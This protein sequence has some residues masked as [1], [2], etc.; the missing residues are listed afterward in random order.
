MDGS[1]YCLSV[2]AHLR[3]IIYFRNHVDVLV[4]SKVGYILFQGCPL[5]IIISNIHLYV[6]KSSITELLHYHVIAMADV[7]RVKTQVLKEG[8]CFEQP[9]HTHL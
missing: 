3:Y 8:L 2:K 5:I 4:L 7:Q 9:Y 1:K 6:I